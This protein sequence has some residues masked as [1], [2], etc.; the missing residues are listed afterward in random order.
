MRDEF[1][2]LCS[3]ALGGSAV[4]TEPLIFYGTAACPEGAETAYGS[5]GASGNSRDAGNE[6]RGDVRAR[7]FWKKRRDCIFDVRITDTDAKSYG[8][9]DSK[10]ILE[11]FAREKKAKYKDACFERRRDFTPLVYS[12]DGLPC[13]EAQDAER[14]LG[15]LLAKKWERSYSEM[16]GYVRTRM[17]LAVVR[18][19][20]LMLRGERANTWARR[21]ATDGTMAS[22]VGNANN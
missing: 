1:A 6:A 14:R 5:Q 20:T 15:A 4:G 8:N 7:G 18:A 16:V 11:R 13:K 2:H 19:N 17:S 9:V 12:V 10:K 22:S 3:Q 21:G